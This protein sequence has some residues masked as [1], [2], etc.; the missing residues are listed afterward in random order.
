MKK[1]LQHQLFFRLFKVK[2]KAKRKKVQF[3]SVDDFMK[4]N[5]YLCLGIL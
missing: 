1:I 4:N 2:M 3:H 5:K